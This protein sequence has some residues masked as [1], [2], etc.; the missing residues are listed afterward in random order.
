MA[1]RELGRSFLP[2]GNG[3]PD[4]SGRPSVQRAIQVLA[5]RLPKVLG[6]RAIAPAPLLEASGGQMPAVLR[7]LLQLMSA[8][9]TPAG[10]QAPAV[11]PFAAPPVARGPIPGPPHGLRGPDAPRVTGAVAPVSRPEVSE[12]ERLRQATGVRP[13]A[14]PPR[15]VFDRPREP[16]LPLPAVPQFPPS[17][18]GGNGGNNAVLTALQ[19]LAERMRGRNKGA[20]GGGFG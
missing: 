16:N 7:S 8:A 2:G 15:I 9:P 3:R 14:E 13:V 12:P 5:L 10:I 20:F 6:D 19:M 11:Q 18:G 4:E 1:L 17:G